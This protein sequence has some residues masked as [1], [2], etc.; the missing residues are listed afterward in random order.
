MSNISAVIDIYRMDELKPETKAKILLQLGKAI[1]NEYGMNLTNA[2][3][4]ELLETLPV[5]ISE[6]DKS[7]LSY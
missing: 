5:E 3:I 4:K 7:W 2:L 6:N 1:N